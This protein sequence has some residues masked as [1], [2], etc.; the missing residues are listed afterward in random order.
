M[1]APYIQKLDQLKV[2]SD[3]VLR[4]YPYE[5][6]TVEETRDELSK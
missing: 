2:K 4:L 6:K 3:Q 1:L 5:L